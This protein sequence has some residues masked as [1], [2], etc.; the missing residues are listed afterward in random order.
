MKNLIL[1]RH[2][3]SSWEAPQNDFD[4][5]LTKR[6]ISDAHLIS[7]HVI[8]YLPK[9]FIMRSSAAKRATDTAIIFAQNF[10]IPLE[11]IQVDENLYTFDEKSLEQYIR[12]LNN[13]YES[14]I[15]FG[16]NEAITNFVNKFGN[17]FIENVTTSGF[18]SLAFD[19]AQWSDISRGQTKKVLFPRDLKK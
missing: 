10:L 16:H 17:I 3:K 15:L 11:S 4:R 6:G 8:S 19:S 13:D 18:V 1:I 14:V 7:E 9:S 5:P 2:A 12:N